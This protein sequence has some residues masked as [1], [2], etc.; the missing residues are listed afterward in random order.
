VKP[1]LLQRQWHAI[2]IG[3]VWP[4]PYL[5][6]I[7]LSIGPIAADGHRDYS[8]S[9]AAQIGLALG[10]P[11]LVAYYVAMVS[12]PYDLLAL[13]T[14][15]IPAGAFCVLETGIS[16]QMGSHES[17][18][19]LAI[20]LKF[21]LIPLAALALFA[22]AGIGLKRL[23]CRRV[24]LDEELTRAYRGYLKWDFGILGAIIGLAFG[25]C[26]VHAIHTDSF[27]VQGLFLGPR[28]RFVLKEKQILDSPTATEQEK[29]YALFSTEWDKPELGI[30]RNALKDKS[31]KV[32][33]FA[34]V[35]LLEQRDGGGLIELE[36]SLMHSAKVPVFDEDTVRSGITSDYDASLNL[37]YITD[38]NAAP[39]LTRLELSD[40]VEVRNAAHLA[41]GRMGLAK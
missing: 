24:P 23:G 1:S 35:I 25:A 28:E 37:E 4:F 11:L 33:F 19:D 22:F 29:I 38:T 2:T 34:A 8:W 41:L 3:L 9:S 5:W 26:A 12:G 30:I 36:P 31:A 32:R 40:D 18:L 6:L 21:I 27:G 39:I 7:A 14:M 17:G 10:I 20:Y 13:V 16:W 15:L